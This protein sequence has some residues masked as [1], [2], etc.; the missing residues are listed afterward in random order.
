VSG[1]HAVA[2]V[3]V[4]SC[5]RGCR[6]RRRRGD[7]VAFWKFVLFVWALSSLSCHRVCVYRDRMSM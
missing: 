1:V 2:Q 3:F 6:R 7:R 4:P 5:V